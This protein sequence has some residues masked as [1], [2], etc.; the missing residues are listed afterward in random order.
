MKN[1][2]IVTFLLLASIVQAQENKQSYSFSL[3]QAISHALT[4]NR[5]AIN[6]G[7]DIEMAKKKKWETTAMGLPQINGNISYQNNFKIQTTSESCRSSNNGTVMIKAE[8]ELNYRV[9][10]I[11]GNVTRELQFNKELTVNDL[12]AGSYRVCIT[13]VGWDGYQQ[14]YNVVITE[15][16]DLSAFMTVKNNERIISMNLRGSDRYILEINGKIST[17]TNEYIELPLEEGENRIKIRT[18]KDCQGVIERTIRI[19]RSM[20]FPNPFERNL[21]IMLGHMPVNTLKIA[22]RDQK[23]QLVFGKEYGNESGILNIN[24]PELPSGVYLLIVSKDGRDSIYKVM[25]K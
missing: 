11:G 25:R 1:K 18:E 14:C 16:Q 6:A 20:P 7:R 17:T 2:L 23:G 12:Q 4:N 10:I 21:S 22:L 9:T 13:V 24:L 19:E 3:D 5:T 8:K 15:P